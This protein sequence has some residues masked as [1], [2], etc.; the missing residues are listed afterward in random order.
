MIREW[1]WLVL[2]LIV[3]GV[4]FSLIFNRG[5]NVVD[6]GWSLHKAQMI[7]HGQLP[8]RDN[9]YMVTPGSIYLQAALLGLSGG[10]VIA[11]RFY[12]LFQALVSVLLAFFIVRSFQRRPYVYIAPILFIPWNLLVFYRCAHYNVDSNFFA[13]LTLFFLIA[14]ERRMSRVWFFLSAL[15]AGLTFTFK[16]NIGAVMVLFTLYAVF[17]H[18]GRKEELDKLSDRLI[19]AL[20]AGLIMC[21]PILGFSIYFAIENALLDFGRSAILY[22]L[23]QKKGWVI[24]Q[25]IFSVKLWL[26]PMGLYIFFICLFFHYFRKWLEAGRRAWAR[27][28]LAAMFF[29]HAVVIGA[30]IYHTGLIFDWT[31]FTAIIPLIV[32]GLTFLLSRRDPLLS[33]SIRRCLNLTLAFAAFIYLVNIL[34]GIG[35]IH[36]VIGFYCSLLLL[37]YVLETLLRRWSR[38]L[39]YLAPGFLW[40]AVLVVGLI[41]FV[42][43]ITNRPEMFFAHE[44]IVSSR[45]AVNFPALRGIRVTEELKQEIEEIYWL[46]EAETAPEEPILI[47]PLGSFYYFLT[48]RP[49]AFFMQ[50]F[51]FELSFA[52]QQAEVIQALEDQDV[53]LV[54]I[55]TRSGDLG[56]QLDAGY[57]QEIY[58]Y[59][60]QNYRAGPICGRYQ[61]FLRHG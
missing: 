6:E 33:G 46:V 29:L 30:L 39:P 8:Y 4:Y 42:H 12:A 17:T 14:Y 36:T 56:H 40:A 52:H 1:K 18:H 5:I 35:F 11:V 9:F 45:S 16:Q 23:L 25:V 43:L 38:L 28:W 34:S 41:G 60:F 13:L 10:K 61:V 54:L 59:I 32:M 31:V 53:R 27:G 24:E 20:W 55:P 19:R 37:G 57:L 3:A 26:L 47:L 15:S 48:E 51:F 49:P 58:A 2:I 44:P 7:C 21:L 22:A 50:F